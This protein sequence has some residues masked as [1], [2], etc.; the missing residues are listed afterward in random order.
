M[1]EDELEMEEVIGRR[2]KKEKE[3]KWETEEHQASVYSDRWKKYVTG[4]PC[5]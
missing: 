4:H 3:R 1:K 5:T 2:Y